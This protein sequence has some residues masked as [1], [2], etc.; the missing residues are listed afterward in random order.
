MDKKNKYI[1]WFTEVDKDDIPLVGGKGA[2]L[3]E[4]ATF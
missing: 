3:G 1:L 4:M 2:N